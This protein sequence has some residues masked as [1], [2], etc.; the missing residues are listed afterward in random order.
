MSW[1]TDD[2][3]SISKVQAQTGLSARTLRYWE[4]LGLLSGI[5]RR[6]GGRR[7][8]GP[9]EIERLQFIQRLKSLGLS[10]AEIKELNAVYAMAGSTRDMLLRLETLLERHLTAVDERVQELVG[11][12][13][14]IASYRAHVTE[15][16]RG[17]VE[18]ATK[19]SA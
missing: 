2:L 16:V 17:A 15:R 7:V 1:Q 13:S 3:V 4:E 9:D 10:L 18:H 8:Y 19:E 14:E 5:R 11:L 12:R 6:S